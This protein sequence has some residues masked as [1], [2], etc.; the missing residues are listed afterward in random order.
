[1]NVRFERSGPLTELSSYPQWAQD[2]VHECDVVKKTLLDHELWG[3]M[4]SGRMGRQSTVNFMVGTWPLIERF[5]GYMA[6]SLLKTRYG[7]SEGDN[8]ARRWLVRNIRVEQNHAEYWLNWA[9]GAG[10]PRSALLRGPLPPGTQVLAN[11]CEEIGS[12][13]TL[14]AGIAAIN[15][16]VEGATGEWA[17]ILYN[18]DSYAKQ[19]ALPTR[20]TSL[21]WLQLHA[22]YD[23]TH[24]WEALEIVCT[25]LGK[26]P[27]VSEVAHV[28]ECA[29]RSHTSMRIMADHCVRPLTA[30]ETAEIYQVEAA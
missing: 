7:R 10:I 22:A 18:S 6:Q 29:K 19:F 2:M 15:Y 5:P 24:P 16:A 11:W 9:E 30:Q 17:S 28:T 14:A 20:K 25:L 13:G 8:L 3:V 27:S 4:C 1:M 23:D 12:R 21:R 26:S